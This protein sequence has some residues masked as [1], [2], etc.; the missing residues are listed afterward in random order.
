MAPLVF[1]LL[2]LYCIIGYFRSV[3]GL[4]PRDHSFA[5]AASIL[6]PVR[7]LDRD[8]YENF[9]SFCR[10]DYP[11]YELVFAVADPADAVIPVI[12]KLR[13][14][15]PTVQIRLISGVE[16]IGENNK[17]NNLCRLVKEER[18]ELLVM[19]ESDVRVEP[20]YLREVVAPF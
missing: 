5:P 17:V 19:S 6:K 4:S 14:D 13:Q 1:Y 16:Q 15:Y 11:E 12:E 3:R 10:L 20:D 9:A 18:Y 7:G 2:C 8:A